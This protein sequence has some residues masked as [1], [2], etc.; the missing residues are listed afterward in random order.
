LTRLDYHK[1][2]I[3]IAEAVDSVPVTQHGEAAV[4]RPVVD[5]PGAT[6]DQIFH[7]PT[8]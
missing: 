1:G 7:F 8:D 2:V 5:P 4:P 3:A 6:Y